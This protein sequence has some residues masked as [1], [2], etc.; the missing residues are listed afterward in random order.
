[1]TASA[2]LFFQI[3]PQAAGW[4]RAVLRAA[5]WPVPPQALPG[6]RR[7]GRKLQE[8]LFPESGHVIAGLQMWRLHLGGGADLLSRKAREWMPEF[9]V[10]VWLDQPAPTLWTEEEFLKH[11]PGAPMRPPIHHFIRIRSAASHFEAWEL[12]CGSGCWLAFAVQCPPDSFLSTEASAYRNWIADPSIRA[13]DLFVPLLRLRSAESPEFGGRSRHLAAVSRYVRESDEDG[14][15]LI[16]SDA[17]LEPLLSVLGTPVP[18]G[19][20]GDAATFR[21]QP[22]SDSGG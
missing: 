6:W 22:A 17:P 9:G 13:F 20:S 14:G 21:I 16:Y 11:P 5:G 7:A 12:I 4:H 2:P 10:G 8:A 3:Y 18:A 1:M 15:L 19:R